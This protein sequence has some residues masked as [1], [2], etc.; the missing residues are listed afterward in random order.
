MCGCV[1]V[2]V[3]GCVLHRFVHPQVEYPLPGNKGKRKKAMV[4]LSE[5]GADRTM[6]F[7]DTENRWGRVY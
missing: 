2:C 3:C 5:F 6:F 4:G 1:R 7:N